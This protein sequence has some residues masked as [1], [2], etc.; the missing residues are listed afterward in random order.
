MIFA[1]SF[2]NYKAGEPVTKDA[3]YFEFH[4]RGEVLLRQSGA[5]TDYGL[6]QAWVR[7]FPAEQSVFKSKSLE[8]KIVPVLS[9]IIHPSACGT[10][11]LMQRWDVIENNLVVG[12]VYLTDKAVRTKAKRVINNNG[13]PKPEDAEVNIVHD[14]KVSFFLSN[15]RRPALA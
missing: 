1:N 8:W 5:E 7:A 14:S 11:R 3:K 12:H 6:R 9:H 13:K 15:W 2:L 4:A 10:C